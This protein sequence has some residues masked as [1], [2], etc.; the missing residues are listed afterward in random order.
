MCNCDT[1]SS[2]ELTRPFSIILWNRN[3]LLSNRE[4]QDYRSIMDRRRLMLP[5]MLQYGKEVYA[6]S[7]T[8]LLSTNTELHSHNFKKTQARVTCGVD[9]RSARLDTNLLSQLKLNDFLYQNRNYTTELNNNNFHFIIYSLLS[10]VI[11]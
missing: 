4:Y 2:L 1:M 3:F 7:W 11:L 9:Y 10:I 5:T 8:L 6:I